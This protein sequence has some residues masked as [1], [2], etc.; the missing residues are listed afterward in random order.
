MA[1]QVVARAHEGDRIFVRYGRFLIWHERILLHQMKKDSTKWFVATPDLDLYEEDLRL[2]WRASPT[3]TISELRYQGAAAG[4]P[5]GID[6]DQAYRFDRIS[7]TQLGTLLLEG[8]ALAPP[9]AAVEEGAGA[10]AEPAAK[11]G[12]RKKKPA[13]QDDLSKKTWR[14]LETFGD[15]SVGDEVDFDADTAVI[16]LPRVLQQVEGRVIAIGLSAAPESKGDFL[17]RLGL[18][19]AAPEADARTMPVVSR[20]GDQK[21]ERTWQDVCETV[22]EELID[23]F[24]VKGPRT[25]LWCIRFLQRQQ[26]HPD[27]Y[28]ARFRLRHKLTPGD[29][30]VLQHGIALRAIALA[31]CQDQ[32]DLP[33]LAVIE[34]LVREAQM[35]EYYYK[36]IERDEHEKSRGQDKKNSRGLALDEVEYFQG[37][38]KTAYD[39]MI[40]PA[41]AEWIAKQAERDSSIAKQ[42]RKAREERALARK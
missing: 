31:G 36:Q 29:W 19:E 13:A 6:A 14:S 12:A 11:A 22:S 39:S 7:K 20:K 42:T 37:T 3:G 16:S 8:K 21:R 28:H 38:D 9:S 2:N 17:E 10:P 34:S 1:Q 26:M 35:S 41:L 33:N 30:G 32:L 25:A 5:A 27:D 4:V 15:I 24:G 18:R 40:C 23:D